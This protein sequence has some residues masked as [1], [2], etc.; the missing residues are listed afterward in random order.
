[1]AQ[2]FALNSSSVISPAN[3][4]STQPAFWINNPIRP[5]ELRPSTN[6]VR[7]S[8]RQIYSIVVAKTNCPGRSRYFSAWISLYII[9]CESVRIAVE[10]SSTTLKVSPSLMSTLAG[11]IWFSWSGDMESVP[12]RSNDRIV[13]SDKINGSA[14][15][16]YYEMPVLFWKALFR[17]PCRQYGAWSASSRPR[18]SETWIRF[19]QRSWPKVPW[20][21]PHQ[22]FHSICIN[23]IT[24]CIIVQ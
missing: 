14:P 8:G 2:R 6:A 7:L 22:K 12:S 1:M 21:P 11:W 17:S 16:F 23:D 4:G 10:E 20:L 13:L 19:A 3:P 24:L 18:S 15:P 5:S 9:F